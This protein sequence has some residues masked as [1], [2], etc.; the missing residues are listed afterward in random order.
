VSTSTPPGPGSP[1]GGRR[2]GIDGLLERARADLDRPGPEEAFAA[3]REG[4]VLVDTRPE[5]QRRADGD[6]P[7]ALVIE[8]NHLEWRLDPDSSGRIPEACSRDTR[9]IVVCDEGYA[10]SL[11][12]ASLRAVGLT[13]ATDL[14]GGFQAW[15]AADLPVTPPGTPV[16]PR[17][18]P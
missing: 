11:A 3:L 13:S 10:S 2:D 15:R 17:L 7:G 16:P 6:I 8:R 14:D 18:A 5:F 4:A 12:A 1:A 9:W